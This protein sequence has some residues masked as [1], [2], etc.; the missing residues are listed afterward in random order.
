MECTLKP[1]VWLILDGSE[2]LLAPCELVA[3]SSGPNGV[4]SFE[5]SV[6]RLVRAVSTNTYL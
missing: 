6:K 3:R 5:F 1:K 4:A 2:L